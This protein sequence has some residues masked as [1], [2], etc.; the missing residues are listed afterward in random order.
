MAKDLNGIEI[1]RTG[2]FQPGGAAAGRKI[3]IGIAE[4]DQMVASFEALTPIGGFTPV[5]KL[6]HAEAQKFMGQT[7]GAPNLGIVGKIFREGEKVLANFLNVPDAVVDL[8]RQKRFANVSVEVVPNLEFDG[9][10]F[11]QVL[12]A[13]ALLGAELPA[14]KGLKELASVLFTEVEV[15]PIQADNIVSYEQET[16]PMTVTYTQEQHDALVEAAVSKAVEAAKVEYAETAERLTAERDE[17]IEAVKTVKT[18]FAEYTDTVAKAEAETMVDQAIKDGKLLPKQKDAAMAFMSNLTGTVKFDDEDKS[19]RVMFADFLGAM[20]T[21]ID[22]SE[23]GSGTPD[24][25]E[26]YANASTQVD[27]L[28]RKA[29]KENGKLSYAEARNEVLDSDAELKAAYSLA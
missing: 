27:V 9:K 14:V 28:A 11:S 2:T 25:T 12:T 18:N 16:E 8:I 6:G 26:D 5:L 4:L 7:S 17:A 29:M 24:E 21:K 15:K 22:T 13:V 3:T 20:P 23:K 19:M 1:M 10:S